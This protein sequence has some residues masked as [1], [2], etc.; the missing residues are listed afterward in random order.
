MRRS[1]VL[2]SMQ[3]G[4]PLYVFFFYIFELI[5]Y[6]RIVGP[7]SQFEFWQGFLAIWPSL[8]HNRGLV[9]QNGRKCRFSLAQFFG[10]LE[11]A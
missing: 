6:L 3:L 11:M 10:H 9:P 2:L 7:L 5:G 1:V 4:S 8:G